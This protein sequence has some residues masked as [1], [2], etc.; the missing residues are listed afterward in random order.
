MHTRMFLLCFLLSSLRGPRKA[1]KAPPPRAA[2]SPADTATGFSRLGLAWPGCE[3]HIRVITQEHHGAG[4][5]MEQGTQAFHTWTCF[6]YGCGHL[7]P[8]GGR[9]QQFS[10]CCDF[11]FLF[12]LLLLALSS[13]FLLAWCKEGLEGSTTTAI[14]NLSGWYSPRIFVPW[15]GCE[16]HIWNCKKKTS[17]KGFK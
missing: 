10:G 7:C 1:R 14:Y 12:R 13:S 2:T 15:L 16:N 9:S 3:S 5:M 4:N 17:S 8:S 6:S 11:T